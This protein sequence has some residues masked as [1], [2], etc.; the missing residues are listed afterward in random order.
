M[1]KRNIIIAAIAL[2]VVIAIGGIIIRSVGR[3][4]VALNE[5]HNLQQRTH[6]TDAAVV[7]LAGRFVQRVERAAELQDVVAS[8]AVSGRVEVLYVS[9]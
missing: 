1:T 7:S 5:P 4:A 6:V 8:G 2:I 3:D 9:L